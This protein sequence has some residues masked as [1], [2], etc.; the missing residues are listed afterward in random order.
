MSH[1]N[2]GEVRLVNR[3][4]MCQFEYFLLVLVRNR[5][6]LSLL[7][8]GLTEFVSLGFPCVYNRWTEQ[9]KTPKELINAKF[10]GRGNLTLRK[11]DF[12]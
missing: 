5:V 8:Y 2:V 7:C 1:K 4:L 11:H 6:Q 9:Q 12:L 3:K 10:N